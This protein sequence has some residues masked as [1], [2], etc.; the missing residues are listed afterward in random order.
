MQ[1]YANPYDID[2]TGFYFHTL[3]EY[4]AK[5]K[6][7]FNRYGQFVEEYMID[8]LDGTL[9]ELELASAIGLAQY[10]FA[11][12][13][14]AC[15]EWSDDE[16]IRAC[17]VFSENITNECFTKYDRTDGDDVILHHCE[18]FTELAEQMV[19]DGLYGDIPEHLAGYIDYQ[20]IGRDLS[21]N[22][23][24]KVE[25]GNSTYIYEAQ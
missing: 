10:N 19:D 6:V 16:I 20:A 7:N 13:L 25:V 3:E 18:C 8:S 14:E 12:Y 2:A 23:F 4:N 1:L 17:V 9:L 22:G 15:D 24:S 11:A 5:A 21:Y